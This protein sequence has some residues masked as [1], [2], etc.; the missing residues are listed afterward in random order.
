[1]SDE[2]GF[3]SLTRVSELIRNRSVSS[4]E[5]TAAQLKRIERFDGTYRSYTTVLADRALARAEAADGELAKGIWRGP[6]HGVPVAVKDLCNTTFAPT[7]AGTM[8]LRAVVPGHN[9]T[10]VD[11]LEQG[12]AVILGKLSMTEGAYTSHHPENPSPL[13]PWGLDHWVGSS[14]TGS[15]VATAAGLCYGAIGSDTGGS[16]RFPSATCG[17][18][19]IKPT[20][21]RV[22]R[23]G[24]FPLAA[25]LDHIGPMTR[26]A[27]DAA[28]M[29]GVIAGADPH[30]PTALSAPVPDYLGEV[31]RNIRGLRIGIDRRFVSEGIDAQVVAALEAAE[32]VLAGLGARIIEIRFPATTELVR[33]WIPFC[34]VETAIAH[35]ESYPARSRDYGPDLAALIEQGRA[36][37]G[38][39][40]GEI[41]HE[42]LA[43]SGALAAVFQDVD[44]MLVPTMPVPIPSLAQMAAYG[45]DPDVLLRILRFTAPFDFSG[46]PTITLPAGIDETGMPLSLQLVGRHLGEDLL[47]RAGHAFQQVTDWHTHRP[48]QRGG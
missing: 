25:S 28:A 27:A 26:D 23:Y 29:L 11:R 24:V 38:A 14:S 48:P 37:S 2:L 21:G 1:M 17:L 16:I 13:N 10:V 6:L 42:R 3:E 46:S 45:E 44:L 20:W 4:V 12:G 41:Y 32:G 35:K 31:G 39:E 30:D 22:S 34:A 18:T 19:G 43:F 7:G 33:G 5:V 36:M 15:G 8:M 47:C 40:L 9:A